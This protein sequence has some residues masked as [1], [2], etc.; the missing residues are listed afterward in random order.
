[1]FAN[2]LKLDEHSLANIVF[3]LQI[4]I[5]K[6][7]YQHVSASE[8]DFHNKFNDYN[9]HIESYQAI[10]VYPGSSVPKW[11]EYK[12]TTDFVVID[13]SSSTPRS[14]LLGFVLGGN[15]LIVGMLKFNIMICEGVNKKL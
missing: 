6:F 7:A 12:T 8:Q 14:P 11:F 9:D 4:N 10:Y 5:L 13:L 3:N 2:C 15:W 1:V